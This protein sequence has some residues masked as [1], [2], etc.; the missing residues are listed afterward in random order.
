MVVFGSYAR[1]ECSRRSDIDLLVLLDVRGDPQRSTVSKRVLELIG[2]AEAGH[3]LPMHIAPLFGSTRRPEELGAELLHDVWRDGVVLHA[4]A[5]ALA[6]LRPEGLAP[7]TLFRFSAA[8]AAP[9]ERVRLSRH[10]HGSGGRAGIVEPP[11][12]VLGRG[13]LLV[14]PEHSDAVKGALDEAGAIYDAIP[15]WREV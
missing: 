7:W 8:Q 6:L 10:L 3:R 4:R 1:G 5:A 12:L 14:A 9:H 11:S 13:A 15:V 2:S